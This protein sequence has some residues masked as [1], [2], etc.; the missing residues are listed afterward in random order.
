MNEPGGEKPVG[1]S[2]RSLARAV[3]GGTGLLVGAGAVTK[4]FSLVS[5]PILTRLVGPEPYGVVALAGTISSLATTVAMMGVDLSYARYYFDGGTARGEAVERFCWRFSV[6]TGLAMSLLA[7]AVWWWWDDATASSR[8]IAAVVA[9]GTFVAVGIAMATTR[10]RV[11]GGYPRIAM[12]TV[13]GGALGV[14]LSILL[15]LRWRP[16]A[17][18]ML[19]GA[20]VGSAATVAILGIPPATTLLVRSGLD[21]RQRRELLRMGFAS[22]VTAPMFWVM[23]SADRWFLGA[24]AGQGPLGVYAFAS[25]IGLTGMMVNSALTLA[26][27]PEMSREYEASREDSLGGIGRLWARLAGLLMVTWLV[28]AASGGDMIRLLADRRFHEGAPL[29][30]WLAGGVFFYGMAGLAN[31]GLFLRK[32]LAPTAAW[33]VVGAAANVAGNALLVGRLGPMGASFAA[34]AGFAVIASG[35]T[36]SAQSRLYLPIPWGRIL[37]AGAMSLATGVVMCG[38][39]CASPIRSLLVKFPAGVAVAVAVMGIVAP[40]WLRRLVRGALRGGPNP[41]A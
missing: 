15:A 6:G 32:N 21:G 3:L 2:G 37:V 1:A 30:P 39:W 22:A 11:R 38:P 9:A 25:G 8:S 41:G 29:V 26:W 35:M 34:C 18:A 7:G 17:W 5:S 33:W 19:G 24:W 40:D 31:T 14:A 12:A 27:F 4:L 23:C 28:V 13:A 36:W 16:D 20:L 10:R